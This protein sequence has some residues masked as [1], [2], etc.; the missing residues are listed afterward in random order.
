VSPSERRIR[1]LVEE[2]ERTL[3]ES[4]PRDGDSQTLEQIERVT[5]EIGESIKESIQRESI[6]QQ[7]SGFNGSRVRCF[8]CRQMVTARYRGDRARQLVTLHGS[9]T[10]ERAYYHCTECGQGFCPLDRQLAIGGGQLS[11]SVVA[12]LCRFACYLSFREAARELEI[13]CG[14]RLSHSTIT[15]YSQAVG[16]QLQQAHEGK[17][18]QVRRALEAGDPSEQD[19]LC[20]P[21]VR[22][23]RQ[24]I[25]MDGVIIHVGGQWREAKLGCLYRPDRKNGAQDAAYFATLANSAR[26]GSDLHTFA[27]V[28]GS[29][30]CREMA[31]VADGAEWIWQESGKYFAS[32]VQILDFYHATEHLWAVSRAWHGD[33]T[34]ANK[35]TAKGWVKQQQ[36]RFL[37]GKASEVIASLQEWVPTTGES[38]DI[39]RRELGYFQQHQSCGRLDYPKYVSAGFHIGSGV[40]EAGCKNVVQSRM[41]EAGMRWSHKGA[42]S[43][44]YM[45]A[46][47]CSQRG[48]DFTAPARAIVALA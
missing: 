41:K 12:L 20:P 44:L 43:M 4:F 17:R 14:V 21:G 23:I 32:R 45:R 34:E 10:V 9:V 5:E 1:R 16:N 29:L 30:K 38:R 28:S 42:Q 47:W 48:A 7:G 11:A 36:E 37:A 35:K 40:I 3:R 24:Q 33:K 25:T 31:V 19:K 18:E 46:D 15:R 22:P 27:A 2:F 39:K 6:A 13:V 26:F 8:F